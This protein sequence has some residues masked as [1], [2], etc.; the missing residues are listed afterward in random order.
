MMLTWGFKRTLSIKKKLTLTMTWLVAIALFSAVI[1]NLL[2]NIRQKSTHLYN[3]LGTNAH[4]I[5]TSSS[6]LIINNESTLVLKSILGA[7]Q[8]NK[9]IRRVCL[10]KDEKDKAQLFTS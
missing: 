7:F 2:I 6:A 1:A 4:I 9:S 10:Y 8:H 5:G 3:E